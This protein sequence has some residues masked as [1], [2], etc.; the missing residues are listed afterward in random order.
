MRRGSLLF[1]KGMGNIRFSFRAEFRS[2]LRMVT[3]VVA[4]VNENAVSLDYFYKLTID[5]DMVSS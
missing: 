2:Q 1:A 4:G 5:D 3:N